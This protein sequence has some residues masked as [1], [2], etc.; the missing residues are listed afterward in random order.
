MRILH[1]IASLD[2]AVGGPVEFV[3][4]L[5]R[6][7]LLGD[8]LE[9]LTLDDPTTPN[10]TGLTIHA[11]GPVSSPFAFTPKVIH[12]LRKNRHRFDA[13]VIHG[14]WQSTGISTAMALGKVTPYLVFPHGMLDPYFRHAFP[15]KHVKKWIY[16][17]LAEYW[18]LRRAE[19]VL[20]TTE[21][22]S[23]LARRSFWLHRWNSQVVPFG[24]MPPA[25]DPR[26]QVESFYALAP[27]LRNRRFILFLGRI[28][29]KKGCDLLVRAFTRMAAGDPTLHLVLAGPDYANWTAEL[30]QTASE[31][32]VEDRVH[33]PGMITGA[34][35]WGAFR[36]AEAFILPSHQ[37]NFG[38]AVAEALACACPVLLSDKVNIA[39][40]IERDHAGF[41]EPDTLEGTERLL[42]RWI[43][44]APAQ[45]T[46]MSEDALHCFQS[47]YD[48]SR[49]IGKLQRLLHPQSRD[50]D[51][52]IEL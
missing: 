52:V 51:Q 24:A 25:P 46:A 38:I 2:P 32:G 48:L 44:L 23:R 36:A 20:F 7:P 47:R 6:D 16:W 50:A 42:R 13:V 31:A 28:D 33:F 11:L 41:V 30:R 27:H 15:A 29:R 45:R 18:V 19:R 8:E 37:E 9:L 21:E 5:L 4:T 39:P 35:K 17:M 22:E 10:P 34:A 12:W 43:A 14:L 40:E 49:N 1:V 26:S 3:L